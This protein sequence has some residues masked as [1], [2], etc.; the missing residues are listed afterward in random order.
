MG[1]RFEQD[2]ENQLMGLLSYSSFCI[3]AEE[4]LQR[5]DDVRKFAYVYFNI[6]NFKNYNERYGIEAAN[7]C[8]RIIGQ[9]ISAI[10]E[11]SLSAYMGIDHFCSLASTKDIEE[12]VVKVCEELRPFRRDT[13]MQM[14]AGIYVIDESNLLPPNISVDRAKMACDSI[15]NQY[16]GMFCYYDERLSTLY[17]KERFVI[18]SFEEAVEKDYITVWYQPIM[19]TLTEEICGYEALSRWID[20]KHGIISPI[21]YIP[22]LEKYHLIYQ[23]DLKILEC[24][25]RDIVKCSKGKD[26]NLDQV[27]VNL[28]KQD[29]LALTLAEDMDSIVKKYG[30]SNDSIHFEITESVLG[31]DEEG[32]GKIINKFR[33]FGY[34]VWIDDF[35]SGYSSLNTLKKFKFDCLKLDMKFLA[36]FD[37][38]EASDIIIRSVLN[39]AKKLG[40]VTVA[41]GVEN[42][43]EVDYLKKIGC[44][45]IQ[46]FFYSKPVPLESFNSIRYRRESSSMRKYYNNVGRINLLSQDPM[47]SKKKAETIHGIPT[48][49]IELNK[50]CIHYLNANDYYM[51][52]LD[53]IGLDSLEKA[54]DF[55]NY[56]PGSLRQR[57]MNVLL[58][59][60]VSGKPEVLDYVKNGQDCNFQVTP[61]AN[62]RNKTAF[63]VISMNLSH[64]GQI[65]KDKYK[66]MA[67]RYIYYLYNR[68][69]LLNPVSH[70]IEL[71]YIN[72]S[73]YHMQHIPAD[74]RAYAKEFAKQNILPIDQE[75]FLKFYDFTNIEERIARTTS[76][77][78]SEYFRTRDINGK[79][80]WQIYSV[81]QIDLEHQVMYLSCISDV[82]INRIRLLQGMDETLSGMPNNP[83]FLWLSSRALSNVLGYESYNDFMENSYYLE[84]NLTQNQILEMHY[85]KTDMVLGRTYKD[86]VNNYDKA[87][88]DIINRTV[89][90]IDLKNVSEFYNREKLIE[91]YHSG[92]EIESLEYRSYV[93]G[94]KEPRWL[95]SAFQIVKKPDT[96]ELIVYFLTY[97]IDGYKKKKDSEKNAAEIDSLTGIYNRYSGVKKIREYMHENS[98]GCSLIMFDLDNFK[99]INDEYG[100]LCGDEMLKE[101]ARRLNDCFSMY[102]IVCRIG[103]DEFMGV[104]NAQNDIFV[105]EFLSELLEKPVSIMS[106]GK[107]I[108]CNASAGFAMFPLDGEGYH[109]LYKKADISLYQAKMLGKNCFCRYEKKFEQR[110]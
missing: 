89:D 80:T 43:E 110:E 75:R 102:G 66:E 14:R 96:D 21:E 1:S 4:Y 27:S 73:R 93:S 53:S 108:T 82:D 34:Q 39:M 65:R 38:N 76:H 98:Q 42:K 83:I 9:T 36:D 25:C 54:E 67:R 7:D 41:E 31:S 74:S 15:R 32:I 69:D 40:M 47:G 61:I 56:A 87:V 37:N 106:E 51:K 63:L 92:Q 6:E 77:H 50:D 44:E 26:I 100:H 85:G 13:H 107:E 99:R 8:I 88:E 28:S 91:K 72:T 24:V 105:K 55:I 18:E 62:Y 71:I 46:G 59:S 90:L 86:E 95:H 70:T 84:V 64:Y 97:D 52:Y 45:Q 48:A 60:K 11:D 29:F 23:L 57:Y 20:P 19:R 79:Y 12:R 68:V 10:F 49:I 103:G 3:K 78:V 5:C 30:V 104:V 58:A 35:G 22:V 109:D 33:D 17:Q 81:M 94:E 16:D 101:F 2:D